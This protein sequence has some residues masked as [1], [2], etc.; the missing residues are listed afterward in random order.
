[1]FYHKR[2]PNSPIPP[3]YIEQTNLVKQG[4][5]PGSQGNYDE[6]L[7]YFDKVL[8][9]NPNYKEALDV[10]QLI[11]SIRNLTQWKEDLY[12]SSSNSET[13]NLGS[14]YEHDSD[15][16]TSIGKM[17][18]LTPQNTTSNGNSVF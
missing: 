1:M 6:A 9:I 7:T 18:F 2:I 13:T 5:V 12:H 10:K 4:N 11:L 15:P 16:N 3:E 17:Q 14:I 8:A